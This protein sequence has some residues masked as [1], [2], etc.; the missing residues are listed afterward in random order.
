MAVWRRPCKPRA[1]MS[2][3]HF[4]TIGH[5][6]EA[7]SGAQIIHTISRFKAWEVRSP[8]LQMVCDLEV[9]WRSYRRLKT[10]A[11][12]WAGISQPRR[13]LVFYLRNHFW[14]LKCSKLQN[15]CENAPSF[16]NGLWT[17]HF[18]AKWSPSFRMA[19]KMLQA[20]KMVCKNATLLRNHLQA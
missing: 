20:S 19:A 14:A 4:A 13:H 8:T 9:K 18:S 5:I 7:L 16:K 6:F 2:H 10:S 12:S 3:L 1:E 11:Q 17:C 15:G